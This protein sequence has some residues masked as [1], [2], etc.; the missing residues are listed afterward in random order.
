MTARLRLMYACMYIVMGALAETVYSPLS[1][2]HQ[3]SISDMV[4]V[5]PAPRIID[6]YI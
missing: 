6:L 2:P 5:I 1:T 3:R 4:S